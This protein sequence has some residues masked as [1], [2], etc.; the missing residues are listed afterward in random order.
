VARRG[1][2]RPARWRTINLRNPPGMA[3]ARSRITANVGRIFSRQDLSLG[4]AADLF[5][6]LPEFLVIFVWK[7]VAQG[8]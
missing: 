2:R 1:A 4:A 5:D 8:S 6:H 3:F 7:P